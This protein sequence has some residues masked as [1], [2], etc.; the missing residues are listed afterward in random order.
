LGRINLY[1]TLLL[2]SPDG[3][4]GLPLTRDDWYA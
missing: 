2:K 4:S 1:Q 3:Q